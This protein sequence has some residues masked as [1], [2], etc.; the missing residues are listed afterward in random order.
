[1][2][3][4]GR[5]S[6]NKNT[7]NIKSKYKCNGTNDGNISVGATTKP[8]CRRC[9]PG[10]YSYAG[11]S[12]CILC[13]KGEIAPREGSKQCTK[14][15]STAGLTTMGTGATAC[16]CQESMYRAN[17]ANRSCVKCRS[18]GVDCSKPGSTLASLRVDKGFGAPTVVL[19]PWCRARSPRH[20]S[21]AAPKT[22]AL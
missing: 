16:V 14:C 2:I 19:R 8:V 3:Y 17:D 21:V 6:T 9:V 12:E 4:A 11:M 22:V 15:D 20:A 1:M 18:I 13:Y 10:R 7:C 5:S